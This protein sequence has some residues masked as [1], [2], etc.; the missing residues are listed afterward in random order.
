L[1]E[2]R[3]D[4][5][6]AL[7]ASILSDAPIY[8]DVEILMLT[9]SLTMMAE[10]NPL[11]WWATSS[12]IVISR[13]IK[14]S[15]SSCASGK[16]P[17]EL[18]VEL[19]HGSRVRNVAERKRLMEG[20]IAAIE[21]SDDPMI[22]AVLDQETRSRS[23][24]SA[25][26]ER[27]EA[28][29]T[30]AYAELAQ[31][32]FAQYG[33]SVYPDATFTL[34]LS[35]G[36]VKG[37]TDSDGNEIPP[38]TTIGGLFDRAEQQNFRPPWQP[39]Q[40]WMDARDTL[41]M[42]VPLNMVSTLDTIGGNSGS[43]IVNTRGEVVGT[44][45]DGNQYRFPNIFVYCDYRGRAIAVHAAVIIETLRIINQDTRILSELGWNK[46]RNGAGTPAQ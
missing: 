11:L 32:R 17:R 27:I 7:R 22:L 24:R 28:P 41:D 4:R 42:T 38:F 39:A 12:G 43:P 18:A 16:S 23:L 2:F 34:R 14:E 33:T 13:E 30:A 5:L 10:T 21:A 15:G 40:S 29:L 20:G 44:H 3:D 46:S 1:P 6:V 37:Y 25:Y 8:E 26:E 19:I 36:I 45:F 9:D 31:Q 35:Y